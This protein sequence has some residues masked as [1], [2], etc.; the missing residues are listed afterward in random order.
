M[1]LCLCPGAVFMDIFNHPASTPSPAAGPISLWQQDLLCTQQPITG[2][3][4]DERQSGM[5]RKGGCAGAFTLKQF[6]PQESALV[7][8]ARWS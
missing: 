4:A 1:C 3:Y 6:A 2:L 7:G 5:D 8:R